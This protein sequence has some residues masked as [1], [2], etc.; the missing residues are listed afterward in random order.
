MI[1]CA[2]LSADVASTIEARTK[3]LL[4]VNHNRTVDV[5]TLMSVKIVLTHYCKKTIHSN[6]RY[7][8][9]YYSNARRGFVHA[10]VLGGP[11][12]QKN[13]VI[14]IVVGVGK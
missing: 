6:V 5:P 10:V 3:N 13:D 11:L 12:E 4:A 1:P 8:R 7:Q 2:F 14:I 9:N